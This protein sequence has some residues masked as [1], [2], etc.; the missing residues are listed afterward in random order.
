M[1]TQVIDSAELADRIA[2]EQTIYRYSDS[3]TR[4]D[5]E[6]FASVWMPDAIWEVLPPISH[7]V[8][9][10]DNIRKAIC[11]SVDAF[12][13]YVQLSHN[14]VITLLGGGRATATTTVHEIGKRPDGVVSAG[15]IPGDVELYGVYTDELVRSEEGWRFAKRTFKALF[16]GN[17]Q[18]PV[19]VATPRNRFPVID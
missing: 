2:I 1:D 18:L 14:P 9:G 11:G 16:Y 10:Y 6:Q 7:R 5:L 19:E 12:E 8:E 15:L 17:A 3:L 4:G 13:F